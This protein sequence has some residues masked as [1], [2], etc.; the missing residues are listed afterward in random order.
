MMSDP[1]IV[2]EFGARTS[3][4]LL[5]HCGNDQAEVM[6]QGGDAWW[7]SSRKNSPVTSLCLFLLNVILPCIGVSL[8]S[9]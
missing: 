2:I 1:D 9:N 8:V 7:E 5:G 6:R 4:I 3:Q